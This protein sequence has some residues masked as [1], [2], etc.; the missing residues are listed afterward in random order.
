MGLKS[1]VHWH[2]TNPFTKVNG[3]RISFSAILLPSALAGGFD[4]LL[5]KRALAAFSFLSVKLLIHLINKYL[6][7][8]QR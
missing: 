1:L 4:K 6:R 7:W 5:L 8:Q 3:N 2:S